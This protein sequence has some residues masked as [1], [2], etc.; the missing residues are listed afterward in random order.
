MNNRLSQFVLLDPRF[1]VGRR[2]ETEDGM[3]GTA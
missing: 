3:P 2:T 1:G